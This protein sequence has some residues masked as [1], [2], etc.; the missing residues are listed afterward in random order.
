MKKYYSVN[1]GPKTLLAHTASLISDNVAILAGIDYELFFIETPPISGNQLRMAIMSRM[2]A[3]YPG[4]P[5]DTTFYYFQ[6]GK[7]HNKYIVIALKKAVRET[8]EKASNATAFSITPFVMTDCCKCSGKW[9]GVIVTSQ[10]YDVCAFDGHELI[11]FSA[12]SRNNGGVE[13]SIGKYRGDALP[14]VIFVS[15]D[16]SG[17]MPEIKKTMGSRVKD[18][19]YMEASKNIHRLRSSHEFSFAYQTSRYRHTVFLTRSIICLGLLFAGTLALW[20]YAEFCNQDLKAAEKTYLATRDK[21]STVVE[22]KK[23]Y[24]TLKEGADVADTQYSPYR[25]MAAMASCVTADCEVISMEVSGPKFRLEAEATNSLPI[26]RQLEES[27]LFSSI[28]LQSSN[29]GKNGLEHFY[30]SGTYNNEKK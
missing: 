20:R 29:V 2:H 21:M 27:S 12:H 9:I 3:L 26:V 11:N 7:N 23:K 5:E 13:S 8:Y 22:L 18:V 14:L 1:H 19:Y 28:V 30:I 4:I 24:Q 25:L 17:D 16:A 15:D 10:W 6:N